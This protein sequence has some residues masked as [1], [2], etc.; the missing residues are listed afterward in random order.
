MLFDGKRTSEITP[1]EL[2][3]LVRDGVEENAFL[4]YKAQPYTRDQR[5]IHELIKEL[6]AF[7]S[8]CRAGGEW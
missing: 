7:G 6:S 5:G 1:D 8:A 4:D 3:A 2:Q